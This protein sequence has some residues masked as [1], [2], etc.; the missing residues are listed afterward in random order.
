MMCGNCEEP[1]LIVFPQPVKKNIHTNKCSLCKELDQHMPL[2]H[3]LDAM[4]LRKQHYPSRYTTSM[5]AECYVTFES[6]YDDHLY[7]DEGHF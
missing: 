5:I 6:M 1:Q 3:P 4:K 7:L 2:I